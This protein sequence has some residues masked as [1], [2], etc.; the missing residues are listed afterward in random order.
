MMTHTLT[1]SSVTYSGVDYYPAIDLFDN[2]QFNLRL[3]NIKK[4]ILP[5]YVDINWGDG[6]EILVPEIK[7][8]REYRKESIIEEILNEFAPPFLTDSYKH[9]YYPSSTSLSKQLS[10]VVNVVYPTSDTYTFI[11]P[12]DVR[13]DSFYESIEDLKLIDVNIYNTEQ[14][15]TNYVFASKKTSHILELNSNS[16]K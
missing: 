7:V 5:I 13:T 10:C 11:I 1:L 6:S 2:T 12:I 16:N 14:N 4:E 8:I 15:T 9:I 3:L